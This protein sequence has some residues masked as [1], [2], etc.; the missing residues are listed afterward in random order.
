MA[1]LDALSQ[2]ALAARPGEVIRFMFWDEED[3]PHQ[4]FVSLAPAQDAKAEDARTLVLDSRTGDL[5]DEPGPP[6]GFLYVMFKL[7]VDLF[8][9]LPGMPGR[10]AQTLSLRRRAGEGVGGGRK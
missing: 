4:T 9:G 3:H 6:G 7:H 10:R 5:L 1:S 2:S 8:A